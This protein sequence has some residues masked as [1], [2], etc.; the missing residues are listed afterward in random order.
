MVQR[1]SKLNIKQVMVPIC[2]LRLKPK[3]NSNLETQFLFGERVTIINEEKNWYLCKSMDDNYIGYVRRS[4]LDD[5]KKTNYKI[6][7]LSSFI[8]N[9][10]DIKSGVVSKLFLNSKVFAYK[11]KKDWFTICFK[12]KNYFIH[13]NDLNIND[14][15]TISSWGDVAQKFLHTPYLWGG[16]SHLGLDCSALVQ[17]AFQSANISF[18]RNSNDQFKSK[19]L[20]SI[21]ESEMDKGTL[22]FWKGHVAIALNKKNIIHSNAHHMKVIVEKFSDAKKRIESTYGKVIGFKKLIDI[23]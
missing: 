7:N 11:V 9:L 3:Y 6:A 12:N 2:D 1:K 18:P 23:L 15:Y 20:K 10:P 16:K 4:N 21:T 19:V 22:V 8:Y 13:Y 14:K 17:L 5:L